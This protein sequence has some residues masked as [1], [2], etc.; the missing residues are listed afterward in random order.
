[1]RSFTTGFTPGRPRT[2]VA[3]GRFALV[4]VRPLDRADVQYEVRVSTD[5]KSWSVIPDVSEG[6]SDGLDRRRATAPAS[7]A[8]AQFLHLVVR[9]L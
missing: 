9:P 7:G 1:M 4:Y 2:D 8:S 6:T 5:L 3:N